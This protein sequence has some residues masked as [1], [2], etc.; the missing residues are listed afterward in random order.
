MLSPCELRDDH[1]IS[2][3]DRHLGQSW[4]PISNY[5][6]RSIALAEQDLGKTDT[7]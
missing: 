4:W 7:C 5:I 1:Y 2:K 3:A 6:E